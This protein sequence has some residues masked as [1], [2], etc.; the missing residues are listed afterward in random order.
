MEGVVKELFSPW[1]ET[2]PSWAQGVEQPGDTRPGIEAYI[3]GHI[4]V[5]SYSG[6]PD[7]V[8]E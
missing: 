4:V 7:E 6:Y 5:H 3:M 8:Y 1:W 2:D